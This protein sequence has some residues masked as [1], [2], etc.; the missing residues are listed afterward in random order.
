[1]P[2]YLLIRA[3]ATEWDEDD[4][5]RGDLDVPVS[6]AGLAELEGRLRDVARYKFRQCWAGTDQPADETAAR[7][8]GVTRCRLRHHA[9]LREV[10][11][12]L[13]QGLLRSDVRR[14]H[15]RVYAEWLE[16]PAR[17]VPAGG[18][19]LSQVA[20]RVRSALRDIGGKARPDELIALVTAPL[21]AAVVTCTVEAR[22]LRDLWH[23]HDAAAPLRVVGTPVSAGVESEN[24]SE[25]NGPGSPPRPAAMAAP[26]ASPA[27]KP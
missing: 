14:K 24:R 5:I 27:H 2:R 6:A 11:L 16:D 20:E 17:F 12:G 8:A 4:R 19:A 10:R 1:M 25:N 22:P 21:V 13:W 26:G 18:E 7:V 23:L 9:G 3:A 15:R